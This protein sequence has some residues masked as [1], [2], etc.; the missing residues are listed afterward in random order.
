MK[1]IAR[2]NRD[3]SSSKAYTLDDSREISRLKRK[4]AQAEKA[5]RILQAEAQQILLHAGSGIRMINTDFTIKRINKAFSDMSGV[6]IDAAIGKK[7]WNVFPSPFCH[8][9][10]CRLRRILNGEKI[11]ETEIERCRKDGIRIPCIVNTVPLR[12]YEGRLL[13]M[14]ELFTDITEKKLLQAQVSETEE[15]NQALIELGTN[16]GEVIIML[17]DVGGTE[18]MQVLVN[19]QWL[20]ITGYTLDEILQIPFLDMVS[21]QYREEAQLRYRRKMAGEK[22]PASFDLAIIRKD[23]TEIAV[24]GTDALTNYD[25]RPAHALFMRD[26]TE[27][28]AMLDEIVMERDKYRNLFENV[29]IG[30]WESDY[31]RAKAII[32]EI[33]ASGVSDLGAYFDGHPD[34]F[35]AC[36]DAVQINDVNRALLDLLGMKNKNEFFKGINKRVST[37]TAR[38]NLKK[39]LCSFADGKT[40]VKF[41][42]FTRKFKHE[43][44]YKRLQ[45]GIAPGY[46]D[47][48]A[49]IYTWELDITDLKFAEKRLRK[50]KQQLEELV[51]KRTGEL[52]QANSQLEEQMR[53][54]VDFTRALVHELKTPLTPM[55]GASEALAD[56]LPEGVLRKLSINIHKGV[57]QLN[58]RIDELLDIARGEIGMLQLKR[59]MIDIRQLMDEISDE[60]APLLKAKNDCLKIKI[61]HGLPDIPGDPARIKQVIQNLINNAI[62]HSP[63]GITITVTGKQEKGS[64]RIEINDT[65]T[66]M[67]QAVQNQ[68]FQMYYKPRAIGEEENLSGLGVGLSLCKMLVELHGGRIWVESELG[69]GSTFI[70]TLPAK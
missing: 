46:E 29:P 39:E 8:T 24:G 32:D 11:T 49:K 30:I 48:W 37:K 34:V 61:A 54:R 23:G 57:G 26:M 47:S 5:N 44:K 2:N 9:D 6:D 55:L 50:H 16:M 20:R 14:L 41:D 17:Q 62:K 51:K 58:E 67:S 33:K 19:N 66:G 45:C 3:N 28:K 59:G 4:L 21:P 35:K 63:G 22:I 60:F 13:G 56:Q 40:E 42:D 10:E 65:G 31:S 12:S 69:Q 53:Q 25:G 43:K 70:F 18:G 68:L 15:R 7:C 27:R 36:Q 38:N 64:V 52:T 1:D